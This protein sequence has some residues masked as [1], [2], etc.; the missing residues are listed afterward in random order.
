MFFTNAGLFLGNFGKLLSQ[1]CVA[2]F[3]S[4]IALRL[5]TTFSKPLSLWDYHL[6]AR[7]KQMALISAAYNANIFPCQ[8]APLNR[9]LFALASVYRQLKTIN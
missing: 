7:V 1:E 5:S 3:N 8:L 2:T 6:T 9:E 4:L